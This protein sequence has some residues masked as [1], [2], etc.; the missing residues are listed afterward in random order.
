MLVFLKILNLGPT[1][2]LIY[3]NDLP[4]HIPENLIVFADDTSAIIKEINL[5]SLQNEIKETMKDLKA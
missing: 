3:I 1:L 5:L 4:A 2:F